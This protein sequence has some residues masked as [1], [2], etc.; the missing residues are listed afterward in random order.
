MMQMTQS[1]IEVIQFF[2]E[3]DLSE[4]FQLL[5]NWQFEILRAAPSEIIH[6]VRLTTI[7]HDS[8]FVTLLGR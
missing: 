8:Q 6:H 2:W 1:I 7:N 3:Q 4:F 5:Q